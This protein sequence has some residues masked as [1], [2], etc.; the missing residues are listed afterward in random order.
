MAQPTR[1]TSDVPSPRAALFRLK[2]I[3]A[4]QRAREASDPA[5]R[6]DWEE[7]AIE[8]HLAA[9]LAGR[10]DPPRRNEPYGISH[11]IDS[12]DGT[13]HAVAQRN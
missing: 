8:W 9:S 7:L 4:E 6:Q 3:A 10:G 13:I 11:Y 2:A 12:L 1:S 5:Q